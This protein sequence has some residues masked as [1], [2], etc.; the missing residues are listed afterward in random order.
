MGHVGSIKSTRRARYL[1]QPV[2]RESRQRRCCYRG[3][4]VYGQ[5]LIATP[6][7][8]KS[9]GSIG[10]NWEL[11]WSLLQHRGNRN[12][13]RQGQALAFH[14]ERQGNCKLIG[15][16]FGPSQWEEENILVNH[17]PMKSREDNK[18]INYF[19]VGLLKQKPVLR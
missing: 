10:S 18:F 11:D 16:G 6:A 8:R 1:H 5:G 19:V 13:S 12:C 4:R 17:F 7:E 3:P 14:S 9:I 2:A 15:H